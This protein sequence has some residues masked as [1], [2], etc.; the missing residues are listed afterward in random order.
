MTFL[1]LQAGKREKEREREERKKLIIETK[2]NPSHRFIYETKRTET[3]L[4][5]AIG[6]SYLL[7]LI[8]TKLRF[9]TKTV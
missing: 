5:E 1:K 3:K 8:L 9:I 2:A 6:S 4:R 7:I